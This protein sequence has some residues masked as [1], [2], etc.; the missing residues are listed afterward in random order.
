MARPPALSFKSLL[1]TIGRKS[2]GKTSGKASN[3]RDDLEGSIQDPMV[4]LRGYSPLPVRYELRYMVLRKLRAG[5]DPLPDIDGREETKRDVILS[6]LSCSHP[7]LVSREGTG[8]TRLAE[9]LAKLLPPAPKV[10]GCPYNC[11]PKWPRDW[12]CPR[13]R[14]AEDPAEEFGVEFI[15]GRERFSRIQGNE[16]TNEAKILGVKDIQ[17]IVQGENPS[18]PKVFIGTGILRGNRGIV[19][20]D[21]LPAIP[22]K[23]Q[24]LFHPIL[25]EGKIILEEYNWER[26]IDIFFIATGNPSGFAHVNRIPEPL[27]DRLE[28]IPMDLP[29]EPVEREIMLK[30]RLRIQN[31]FFKERRGEEEKRASWIDPKAIGRMAVAPWW[32]IDVI[33]KTSRYTRQCPNIERG[34]SIRGSIKALDHTISMAEMRDRRVCTLEDAAKGLKLALRGRIRLNPD[35]VGFEE[36]PRLTMAKHDMAVEDIMWY[37]IR[38]VGVA[39]LTGLGEEFDREA[40]GEELEHLLTMGSSLLECLDEHPK[41]YE[42]ISWIDQIAYQR[43]TDG[44]EGLEALSTGM[45]ERSNRKALEEY[46]FSALELL[47]DTLIT[48][49][50]LNPLPPEADIFTPKRMET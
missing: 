4:D 29:E 22:T 21:E 24:V 47:A 13:C 8:K 49:G 28:M 38:D 23:V 35:L 46:R 19:C 2:M 39:I 1:I 42:A 10:R 44:E 41:A 20:V 14:E 31:G 34:A 5:E 40:L 43:R 45:P 9:A 48:L 6:V 26:P 17:A 36:D 27:L 12:L 16:Y 3:H 11:D 33:N 25:Q 7:Y 15:S 18:D 30:E 37:A 32:I 50:V